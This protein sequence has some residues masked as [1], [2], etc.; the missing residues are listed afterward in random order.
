MLLRAGFTNVFGKGNASFLH[1][2]GLLT[3]DGQ[4]TDESLRLQSRGELDVCKLA[5]KGDT[6]L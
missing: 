2:H 6:T 4:I 5:T 1:P 3:E